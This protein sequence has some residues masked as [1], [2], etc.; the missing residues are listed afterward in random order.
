MLNF[1]LINENID[2]VASSISNRKDIGLSWAY[3]LE[4]VFTDDFLNKIELKFSENLMWESVKLQEK[5]PR[6]S[7]PWQPDSVIEEAHNIFKSLTTPISELFC[8]DVKFVSINFWDD[9]EKYTIGPHLDNDEIS[10]AIQVY[11][12]DASINLGT[13]FYKDSKLYHKI[14][15]KKNSGYIL[16]NTFESY[17]GMTAI[18]TANRHSLYAIFK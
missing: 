13:E 6:R 4:N 14:P 18:T 5:L 15:W 10:I 11:V 12:N 16:N 3:E 17:H 8:R 1:N 2:T 9:S 7:I